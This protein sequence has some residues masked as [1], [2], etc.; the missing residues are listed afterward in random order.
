MIFVDL[1]IPLSL[2]NLFTYFVPEEFEGELTVGKRV[3]V[4][5]GKSKMYTG[6]IRTIHNNPPTN[7]QAKAIEYVLDDSPIVLEN[8]LKL[9]E[10]ISTY[11]MAN[12]GDVMQMAL[13]SGFKLVS[14]TKV[15]LTDVPIDFDLLDDK[16]YLVVEALQIQPIL[17]LIEI[18]ELLGIKSI[19][20]I[21]KSLLEKEIILIE[22]EVQKKY[23]PKTESYIRINS[24]IYNSEESLSRA[25]ELLSRAPKQEDVLLRLIGLPTFNFTDF[26]IKKSSFAKQFSLATGNIAKLVEK[27]ILIDELVDSSRILNFDGHVEEMPLLDSKQE[28]A[29]ESVKEGFVQNKPVLLHGVTGSGKTEI[30]LHLIKKVIDEG[31]EVLYLLPEIALTAQLINRLQKVFGGAVGIYHSKFNLNEKVEIWNELN[32]PNGKFKIIIGARSSLFL[33]FNNLG[34]I[35]VDEEHENT[36]K[37]YDPAPRYHARDAAV[38]LSYVNKIPVVLGSATPSIDSYY[39][40]KIGKYHLVELKTR[41]GGIAMPEIFCADV[42]EEKK[43][44]I[45]KGLFSDLLL[46]HIQE[47]LD[48]HEQVILFQNRRGYAPM[49]ECDVCGHVEKCVRCDVSLTYHKHSNILR[50]HYCGYMQQISVSCSACGSVETGFKGSGTE[51]IQEEFAK[52]FPKAKL[53]RLDLD[54]T[55]RKYAYQD[56]ITDFEDREID[57]LIGTQMLTKGLDFEHVSVVGV[58]NAD[59]MLGFPDFRAFERAYQLM[60][61]VSGRAGR[62]EKRGKVII[63]TYNPHHAVIRNVIDYDYLSLYNSEIL[64]RKNFYYP[65]FFRLITITFKHKNQNLLDA[66]ADG[67]TSGIK[68]SLA[69]AAIVLGPEYPSIARI[70]NFYHKKTMIKIPKNVAIVEVKNIIQ[71]W[72]DKFK[73]DI[74][75]RSVRY[76][77]DVDPQ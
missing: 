31:K 33:P 21:V 8:H 68:A 63:Q 41:Y 59:Q 69:E 34:L 22:E 29:L 7:Y 47:A 40:A 49:L 43:K 37:Q 56:I 73:N 27:E 62:R 61:Q 24:K 9:W 5:F 35:I 13:P 26:K 2:P 66:A 4:Q 50:C 25:F 46:T 48:N 51:Q 53:A 67:V 38:Y 18:S 16:E 54:T 32:K 30:Y 23:K 10:W 3:V 1:I 42:K 19:H 57:V 11:Y 28:I 64:I 15:L 44:K 14:E 6:I 12:I 70:N 65:P 58:L 75:Y 72:I 17:S 39:N 77:I 36:Y 52:L 45:M 55:K 76:N 60:L 20:P 71:Q 74:T